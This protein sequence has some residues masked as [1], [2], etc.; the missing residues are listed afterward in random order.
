MS[1]EELNMQISKCINAAYKT[2]VDSK[3][4]ELRYTF[5]ESAMCISQKVEIPN[6]YW[7]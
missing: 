4:V 1:T 6:Y 2:R 7:Q 3:L 5:I